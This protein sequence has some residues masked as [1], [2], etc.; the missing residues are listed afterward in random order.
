[1]KMNIEFE[2]KYL[3]QEKETLVLVGNIPELGSW[4]VPLQVITKSDSWK[5]P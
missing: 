2:L 4:N 3:S 1:M 5:K